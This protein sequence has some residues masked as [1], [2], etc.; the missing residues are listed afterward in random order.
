[1]PGLPNT[2]DSEVAGIEGRMRFKINDM[3]AIF[4]TQIQTLCRDIDY[5]MSQMAKVAPH[6][7]IAYLILAGSYVSAPYFQDQLKSRYVSTDEP[8]KYA[9]NVKILSSLDRDV[10]VA[11]GLVVHRMQQLQDWP[12]NPLEDTK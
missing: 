5:Q 11:K 4:D 1:V 9:R 7:Q 8:N 2:F 12:Q 3:H 10:D 6:D